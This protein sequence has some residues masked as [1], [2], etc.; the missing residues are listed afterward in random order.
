MVIVPQQVDVSIRLADEGVPLYAIARATRIPSD[1]LREHLHE[2]L[3]KGRLLELPRDDWPPGCPRDQ[4]ALQLSRLVREDKDALV[5]SI[6]HIFRLDPT[7]AHILLA[8]LQ[9]DNFALARAGI[10]PNCL[11]VHVCKMRPR[12]KE[13]NIEIV[14]L[15]GYGFRLSS[16]DRHKIMDLVIQRGGLPSPE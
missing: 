13:F 5:I 3:S 11:R 1:N 12:L 14:T 15:W 2:A 8:L 6:Q 7:K 16:D 4:R 10:T 9:N